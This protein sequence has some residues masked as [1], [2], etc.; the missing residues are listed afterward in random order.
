[1]SHILNTALKAAGLR[2]R[3]EMEEMKADLTTA[4]DVLANVEKSLGIAPTPK[5]D[6]QADW[7]AKLAEREAAKN[8][9]VMAPAPN[10]SEQV[11]V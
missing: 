2:T 5:P 4:I 8:Y 9:K 11:A 6:P 10:E 1:M 3:V 7:N